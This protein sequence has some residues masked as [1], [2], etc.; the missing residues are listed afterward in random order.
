MR[1]AKDSFVAGP[2]KLYGADDIA[3]GRGQFIRADGQVGRQP[4]SQQHGQGYEASAAGNG[5]DEADEYAA[6]AA[7]Q[8]GQG[9]TAYLY[10][11]LPTAFS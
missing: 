8:Q 11:V 6:D 2:D 3:A 4:H 1:Q 7:Q 10:H 9:R 5:I